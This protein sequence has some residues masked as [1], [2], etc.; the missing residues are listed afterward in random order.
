M[1]HHPMIVV[2]VILAWH[3]SSVHISRLY[4]LWGLAAAAVAS[5]T[6]LPH[7]P[8]TQTPNPA[9]CVQVW[10]SKTLQCLKTLEGHEDNVRVLAVGQ[11]Y[12]FSGSWDKTIR[13]WD[14]QALA[15]VKVGLQL[16]EPCSQHTWACLLLRAGQKPSVCGACKLWLLSRWPL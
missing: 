7:G 12:L 5:A 14:L 6:S 3:H 15:F 11:R 9:K 16:D 13:V 8:C 2:V 1:L 4:A 10:D